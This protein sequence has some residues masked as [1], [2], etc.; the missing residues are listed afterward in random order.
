MIHK[1]K[2][3]EKVVGA[4]YDIHVGSILGLPTKNIGFCCKL[5]LCFSTINRFYDMVGKKKEKEK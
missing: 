1:I 2:T 4:N 5:N 3:L